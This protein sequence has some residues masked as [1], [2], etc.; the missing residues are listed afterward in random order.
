VCTD[1]GQ[2]TI[3]VQIGL[4]LLYFFGFVTVGMVIAAVCSAIYIVDAH[5]DIA[6]EALVTLLL[7][8]NFIGFL[9]TDQVYNWLLSLGIKQT[10][11]VFGSVQ[12]VICALSIL[13]YIFGK[14]NRAFMHH[15]NLF[16]LFHVD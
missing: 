6:V 16:K 2:A 8:K 10:F 11:M 4:F 15:H 1:L 3:S 5:R 14:R 13:M 7:F 9:L 12:V